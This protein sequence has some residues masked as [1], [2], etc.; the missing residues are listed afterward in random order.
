M[1][2]TFPAGG[3]AVGDPPS[4]TT[5]VLTATTAATELAIAPAIVAISAARVS[6]G[7]RVGAG[8]A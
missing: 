5:R 4:R 1:T 3:Q 6:R 7:R 2:H 8:A